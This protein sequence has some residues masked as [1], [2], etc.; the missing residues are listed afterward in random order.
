MERDC[1][2]AGRRPASGF[3]EEMLVELDGLLKRGE[4][5]KAS[6]RLA[7][8]RKSI[9]R[10]LS[11]AYVPEIDILGLRFYVQGRDARLSP[12]ELA[13]FIRIALGGGCYAVRDLGEALFPNLGPDG[14]AQSLKVIIHR[15]RRKLEW[16]DVLQLS[17]RGYH[18]DPS[19]LCDFTSVRNE[20]AS[21]LR[22]QK[23]LSPDTRQRCLS[24]R[25]RLHGAYVDPFLRWDWFCHFDRIRERLSRDVSLALAEDSLASGSPSAAL[26]YVLELVRTDPIGEDA[27]Q[28]RIRAYLANGDFRGALREFHTF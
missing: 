19:V 5:V 12:T 13:V 28:L 24:F 18:L 27:W 25:G 3:V 21:A 16:P 15:I 6:K 14:A 1:N 8:F 20:I 26:R 10:A 11:V 23:P 22:G 17:V 7:V 9:E 2:N 4:T